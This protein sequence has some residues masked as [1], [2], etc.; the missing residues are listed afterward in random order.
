[1]ALRRRGTSN[2]ALN[3]WP[4]YVD[5]LSTLL[6]V[7]I[8]VLLVFVLAQAFLSV[9]LSGRDRTLDLLKR[10]MAEMSDMLSLER[11]KSA[12]LQ[13]SIAGLNRELSAAAGA[14]DSLTRQLAAAQSQIT[15]LGGERDALKTARDRLAAQLAD[16]ALQA[17]SAEA[18]AT[19]LQAQIDAAANGS[20]AAR[21]DAAN[22]DAKL[23]D[24]QRALA[25]AQARLADMQ[26]QQDALDHTVQADRAIITA[27]LSDLAKMAEQ[28]QALTALRD[29]L[30]KQ[31]QDA[32]A[33]AMTQAQRNAAVAAQLADE[34]K[35]GDS[36]RAQIALLNAQVSQMRAQLAGL[37]AAL[38]ASEKSAAAKDAQ[39]TNLGARLNAALA[40]KVEE[41][42]QYRSD[43]FGRL[44][45]VLAGKQGIQIVGDRFVF[46]SEVLFPSG[47]ADLSVEGWAQIKKLAATL[48]DI[49]KEI[50]PDVPWILR[51][52]GHADRQPVQND[53]F[54]SNW[55]LSAARAITVVKLLVAEGV[56]ADHL[57]ATAFGDT[58]PLDPAN[59]P[60]A[61]AKNRRI[62]LR[63]TSR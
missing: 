27:R 50:P 57:A 54:A 11:G 5:A 15:A 25:A 20:A 42:Q 43:F 23:I 58:E 6:M 16:S 37:A 9:T 7:I 45:K 63:L 47:S 31:A 8:F 40:Q 38:D 18:R 19:S 21:T 14:R 53:R 4:G 52:D 51:V 12:D 32:A 35:L 1:M 56:P 48:L 55:E 41:L 13:L 46:Q 60:A 26:K 44:R 33:R 39:I 30:E 36:A 2:E 29:E 22:A 24:T 3:P 59:T 49:A 62:E 34:K 61:Y 28:V 10:Q 17:Q